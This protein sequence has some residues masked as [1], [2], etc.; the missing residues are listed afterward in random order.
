MKKTLS[1]QEQYGWC[2]LASSWWLHS[3]RAY[4]WPHTNPW[5]WGPG[6]RSPCIKTNAVQRPVSG[7]HC[8]ICF[9]LQTGHPWVILGILK[10][11]SR[12][13]PK[14]NKYEEV[15]GAPKC[16]AEIYGHNNKQIIIQCSYIENEEDYIYPFLSLRIL[17]Q[18]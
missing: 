13:Q 3:S 5:P 16:P 9:S 7:T 11:K 6:Q 8:K 14:T 2:R 10:L 17:S 1:M 18:P 12:Y 4:R 15:H